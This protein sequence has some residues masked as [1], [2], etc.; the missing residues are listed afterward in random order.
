MPADDYYAPIRAERD[1]NV[2]KVAAA[3]FG[4]VAAL[5][6]AISFYHANSV[7]AALLADLAGRPV[8]AAP[9]AAPATPEQS[10]KAARIA[11]AKAAARATYAEMKEGRPQKIF[12]GPPAAA[13]TSAEP[14]RAARIAAAKAAMRATQGKT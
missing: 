11:A 2:A 8:A 3:G 12:Q 14:D 13:E 6:K 5:M 4:N 10:D 9:V 1:A 7:A